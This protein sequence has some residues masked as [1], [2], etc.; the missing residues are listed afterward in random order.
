MSTSETVLFEGTLRTTHLWLRELMVELGWEDQHRAYR[1]LRAVLHA[2]RDRLTIEE[3]ADLAAELPLLVR[4]MYYEGW[5][6]S[7]HHA[8]PRTKE[9]F[10]A[11]IADGLANDPGQFP[12]EVA[13]AVFKLLQSHVSA[14]E[15]SDVKHVLPREITMLWPHKE[16]VNVR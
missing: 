2:L 4:G 12:E 15:I 16:T 3:A 13:W 1:A 14:G 7:A 11:T 9:A 8:M 10:L 6:P 5:R